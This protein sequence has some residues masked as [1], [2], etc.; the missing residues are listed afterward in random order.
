MSIMA[1]GAILLTGAYGPTD[2]IFLSVFCFS[3]FFYGGWVGHHTAVVSGGCGV[4][5]SS[6]MAAT[7]GGAAAN[8]CRRGHLTALNVDD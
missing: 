3:L 5:M 4:L 6:S 2:Q 8:A 1:I 7:V